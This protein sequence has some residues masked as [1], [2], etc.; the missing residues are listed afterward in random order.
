MKFQKA[1]VVFLLILIFSANSQ[2]L[3]ASKKPKAPEQKTAS[4]FSLAERKAIFK[5]V[6]E[7]D[8]KGTMNA[9]RQYPNDMFQNA[10]LTQQMTLKYRREALAKYGLDEDSEEWRSISEEGVR[11]KWMG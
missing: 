1:P 2:A 8:K 11:E 4:R 3:A 6:F 9:D 7:A 10:S 5:D